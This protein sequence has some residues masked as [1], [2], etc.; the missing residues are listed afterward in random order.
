MLS[1]TLNKNK[2]WQRHFVSYASDKER[3]SEYAIDFI[4]RDGSSVVQMEQSLRGFREF[5]AGIVRLSL[6][7]DEHPKVKKAYQIFISRKIS[8]DR[9]LT[10]WK[11]I[12]GLL[13]PRIRQRLALI[14]LVD[15][16]QIIEPDEPFSGKMADAIVT[17]LTTSNESS[18]M[19]LAAIP[20]SRSHE[21][22]KVLISS[23]LQQKTLTVG[24][25]LEDVGCSYPTVL[26]VLTRLTNHGYLVRRG[27]KVELSRFPTDEWNV[28]QSTSRNSMAFA[29]LSGNTVDPT[30][31]LNRL[32][33]MEPPGIALGGV[34]AARYW[35][36]HFNLN[37]TP[38]LDIMVHAP[39]GYVDLSFLRSLDPAL[40]E[41]DQN[42]QAVVVIHPIQR[43]N[44]LFENLADH[45][46][47]AD[48]VETALDLLEMGLTQQANELF[49]QFRKEAR[50]A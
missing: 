36:N 13:S 43:A 28:I 15:E 27:N 17:T 9:M 30:R 2:W 48:P 23:W 25:L 7:L 14:A 37:G 3:G 26:V 47:V 49:L 44:S 31:L 41:A 34:V 16:M 11:R 40:T 6:F 39:Q 33:K 45:V 42:E 12:T 32:N 24:Q 50:L 35:D 1:E 38:R 19:K 18:L 29:D 8:P 21:I 22:V 20:R 4:S 5:Y 46:P 10:E